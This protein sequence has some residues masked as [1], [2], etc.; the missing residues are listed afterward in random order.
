MK[1]VDSDIHLKLLANVPI[2]VDGIGYFQLPTI[3]EVVQMGESIYNSNVSM[4]MFSK[5]YLSQVEGIENFSDMEVMMTSFFYDP[6]FRFLI[7]TSFLLFFKKQMKMDELNKAYFDDLSEETIFTEEKWD[8][9]KNIVR[10][11]HFLSEKTEEDEYVAGN[12]MAK[13]LIEKIKK[14]KQKV[15]QLKKEQVNLHSILSA[16]SWRSNGINP[17]LDLTMYQLYDG[18]YRLGFIDN[19][20]YVSTGIYTGNIDSKGIKLS[21]INW[22]NI[23][24]IN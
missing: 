23:I 1:T 18:Y 22:A 12:D 2:E 6:S 3:R 8:Y 19:Y 15:A 16:V 5:S 4:M 14:N 10:I 21:D 20:H 9:I 7:N 24:K 13:K 17:L 11:S